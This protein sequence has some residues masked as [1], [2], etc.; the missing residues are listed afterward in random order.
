MQNKA[1]VI[2]TDYRYLVWKDFWEKIHNNKIVWNIEHIGNFTIDGVREVEQEVK[3]INPDNPPHFIVLSY[4][5]ESYCIII[6]QQ[7][8]D[9]KQNTDY[10]QK[11]INN[12]C[13][14]YKIFILSHRTGGL[15]NAHELSGQI[16]GVGKFSHTDNDLVFERIKNLINSLSVSN[17]KAVEIIDLLSHEVATP[18]HLEYF[19]ELSLRLLAPMA[20]QK[21]Q[22]EEILQ[23]YRKECNLDEEMFNQVKNDVEDLFS[24]EDK[25]ILNEG[26]REKYQKI[27]G[28]LKKL[29][30][31]EMN[32]FLQEH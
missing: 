18:W 7:W 24:Q 19:L 30:Q 4:A 29:A 3:K 10:V 9:E 31:H 20:N 16:E 28:K 26:Y 27:Y 8:N 14:R 15:I 22:I 17:Q 23:N 5:E 11:L 32:R 25:S 13:Q 12:Y 2:I 6:M 21:S 1:V